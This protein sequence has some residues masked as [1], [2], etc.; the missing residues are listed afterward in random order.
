MRLYSAITGCCY[1]PG[2]HNDIPD[3]TKEIS[4]ELY[5]STIANPERGKVR[6]HDADGLPILIEPPVYKPTIADLEMVERNWR[7]GQVS[8][9]EWLVTRHR[10]EQDM[11]LPTTLPAD[12][13]T[14]LL[15]YRQALRDWPQDSRFPYSDFRPLA[16]PWIN[17]HTQ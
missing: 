13:F 9:S 10:D 6:S 14:T 15:M 17:D 12:Q 16:P 7:D 8:A 5:Q 2:I 1:L 11:F 4:E 3:D